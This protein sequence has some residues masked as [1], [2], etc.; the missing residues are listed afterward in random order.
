MNRLKN[1]IRQFLLISPFMLIIPLINSCQIYSV[2]KDATDKEEGRVV[3][4]DGTEYTGRVKMPKC[5]T[6]KLSIK[7]TDGQ[8]LKLKSTDIAVLG[9]WKKTHT[10]K[11]H[12][13]VAYPYVTNKMFSTKK[14]KIISPQWMALQ[15]QGDYVEFYCC[16]YK[17][18]IPKDGT[19][20]ITSVQNGNILFIARKKGDENGRIIGYQGSGSKHWR[21]SLINY[22]SDDP[23][24]C[25]KLENK[26]IEPDKLQKI[27]DLYNPKTK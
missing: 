6:K 4:K 9:V 2:I 8:K 20:T 5:N 14:E 13:L 10:D 1:S 25:R 24:L 22:L 15:A 18:S 11:C 12:Y 26:E 19:L 16:S 17:Y 3:M 7:T 23:E 27:A 21:T